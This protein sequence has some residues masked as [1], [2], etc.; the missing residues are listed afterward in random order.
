[1]DCPKHIDQ[2]ELDK[3][4]CAEFSDKNVTI[5]EED[6]NG[7]VLDGIEESEPGLKKEG[8][9]KAGVGKEA[10]PKPKERKEA[11]G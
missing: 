10:E 6:E 2:E 8:E 9:S 5:L 7:K 4:I 3:I 11:E 1:M